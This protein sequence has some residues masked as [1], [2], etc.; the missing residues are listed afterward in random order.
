[1]LPDNISI[2]GSIYVYLYILDSSVFQ[3]FMISDL[4]F[5]VLAPFLPLAI[6]TKTIEDCLICKSLYMKKFHAQ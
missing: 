2:W 5:S 6:L 1:M 3:W 4:R